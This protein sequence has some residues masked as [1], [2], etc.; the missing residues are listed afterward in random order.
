MNAFTDE[1]TATGEGTKIDESAPGGRSA[2]GG[3]ALPAEGDRPASLPEFSLRI[4][5]GHAEPEEL[6]AITVVLCAQL[7]SLRALADHDPGDERPDDRRHPRG[8]RAGRSAC[9]SGCWTCS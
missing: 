2:P 8:H 9:W 5:K 7:A 1:S 3:E 4:D 6:A